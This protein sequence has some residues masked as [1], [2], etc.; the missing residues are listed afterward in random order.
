MSKPTRR[1]TI[2]LAAAC[3]SSILS[4]PSM[5]SSSGSFPDRPVTLIVPFGPGTTTD[6]FA[7]LI[8]EGMSMELGQPVVVKNVS[9]AGGTLGLRQMLREAADGYSLAVVT[10]SSIAI[11]RAFYKDLPYDSLNDIS[12]VGVPSTTPNVLVVPADSPIRSVQDLAGWPKNADRPRYHSMGNGTSQ[13]LLSVLMSKLAR[14]DAQHIPYRGQ[15]GMMGMLGGQTQ[16]G[17]ASVPSAAALADAG[18]VRM[19]ASTGAVPSQR[20][21]AVPTLVSLGYQGFEEG[22]S[23]YGVGLSSKAPATVKARLT[24]ALSRAVARPELSKKLSEVGFES[25]APMHQQALDAFAK[26]QVEFW[27]TLFNESGVERQ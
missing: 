10:T 6:I 25:A 5:A 22:D 8:A 11:N 14:L 20:Y 23:W 3:L 9:G 2:A 17:F 1:H 19:L 13:Q 18:R 27:G 21:P 26:R 24:Q 16:F 7:R 12:I 15:D 4:L